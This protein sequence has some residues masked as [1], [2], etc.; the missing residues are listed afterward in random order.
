MSAAPTSAGRWLGT[1]GGAADLPHGRY[2]R[3]VNGSGGDTGYDYQANA[4]A[5]VAAHAL[6]GQPLGWFD[7]QHDI[8]E[9]W[10]AETG[11]PGDDIRVIST[12]RLPIEI[13]A[14][15]G[16]Q[17]GEEY[18][19]TFRKLV[20]GLR[21]SPELRAVLVV[22][23]HASRIIRDDLK[24]DLVRLGQGRTDVITPITSDLL[25]ELG[26][27][28][29]TDTGVFA[30]L[31][32]VVID[33]DDGADGVSV[34]K[35]LLSRVVPPHKSS[36]AYM[37]LGKRGHHM[38]KHRGQ[39]DVLR[40]ARYLDTEVGLSSTTPSPAKSII[41]FQKWIRSTN[42]TFYSPAM[43]RHYPVSHAWN[44]VTPME[45]PAASEA[46]VKGSL[47]VDIQIKRYQEWF[48]LVHRGRGDDVLPAELF[49]DSHRLSVIVGGPGSGKS[50]LSKRLAILAAEENMAVRVR[51]PTVAA[52]LGNAN[53]FERALVEAA[54]DSSG[55][56][57][58]DGERIVGLADLLI[59]DG[60]DECDPHRA[61]VAGALVQWAEGHARASICV[62]TR[63]IGHAPELL[64][65]FAHA[66]LVPLD[67]ADIRRLA[68]WM[69]VSQTSETKS[70]TT[71]LDD[72][73]FALGEGDGHNVKSIAARNPLLL[74]FLVRLFLDGESLDG[75]RSALFERI[76]ELI[77]KSPPLSRKATGPM[78]DK[79]TAWAA[80][81]IAG[82]SC[83][84]RSNRSV[85]DVCELVAAGLGGGL[86]AVRRAESAIRQWT[87]HGLLEQLTVGSLDALV[88]VHLALGEYLAGRHL[89]KLNTE[90]LVLEIERCRRKV[91]WR[92]PIVLA[93][94]SGA[95]ERI[96]PILLSLDSPADP[97]STESVLAAAA[98]TECDSDVV[99]ADTVQS[100]LERLKSRLYSPV[101]VIAVEAGLGLMDLAGWMP[102]FVASIAVE[103]WN[104]EQEWTRLAASCAGLSTGSRMIP[105]DDV[106]RWLKQFRP[107]SAFATLSKTPRRP[108]GFR[109][110]HEA[111]LPKALRRVAE[112]LP[113]ET[114]ERLISAA[115]RQ[116][117]LSFAMFEA[118]R[119]ELSE[120]PYNSWVSR[121]S[122]E[123]VGN[124][125]VSVL[126]LHDDVSRASKA[127]RT[128]YVRVAKCILAVCGATQ[129]TT[130]PELAE[131]RLI[132]R[133]FSSMGY[134]EMSFR[135]FAPL[136]RDDAD[137]VLEVVLRGIISSLRLDPARLGIEAN[138]WLNR[139]LTSSEAAW[140]PSGAKQELDRDA[141]V[142]T[143]LDLN[144]LA[145]ALLH[146]SQFI[147]WNAA[148]LFELHGSGPDQ[149][150]LLK[151]V[152]STGGE[153][154]LL[155]VGSLADTI[156]GSQ[157]FELLFR[158]LGE[159]LSDGCQHLYDPM[160]KA[161]KSPEQLAL[162]VQ[163]TLDAVAQE[164]TRLAPSAAEAL[165]AV[166]ENV[167]ALHAKRIRALMDDWKRRKVLCQECGKPVSGA[168]CETCHIVPPTPRKHLVYL[169]SK[170]GALS[171]EELVEFAEDE[172]LGTQEEGRHALVRLAFENPV[173]LEKVL[174]YIQTG[175]APVRLLDEMLSQP[176]D[177]LGRI[178]DQILALLHS[179]PPPVRERIV[180]SLD[181]GWL[182]T[183][184]ARELAQKALADGAPEVRSR[185]VEVLRRQS[186]V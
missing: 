39:D 132:G 162:A 151:S 125:A 40:C 68:G 143:E 183:E 124:T 147:A 120:E 131:Y 139:L 7:G 46:S 145:K 99:S 23:R 134:W 44:R 56:N 57:Y 4:I 186:Q 138:A 48:R 180:R 19:G 103:L 88:F 152:L 106:V 112:D 43:Q 78:P 164:D 55:C 123:L 91:K 82:W 81:E 168:S 133:L 29:Y 130:T 37:L 116:G 93:A 54:I 126:A 79:P 21:S 3:A 148:R 8:P 109:R 161:A 31:R 175:L 66:E 17:R 172:D 113:Q 85:A 73:M 10:L 11:G 28:G 62:L 114:A 38:I 160:I 110:L 49:V 155:L 67:T 63:P 25:N 84:D 20:N 15:H 9:V 157:A 92:E 173:V 182:A 86:E 65:G 137:P 129:D 178:S 122:G 34:A 42:G 94:G 115:L 41:Q 5:Y 61:D 77:R 2:T 12:E 104:H 36:A 167:L 107:E 165:R 32:I 6:A 146:P 179:S 50:T 118:A 51:L 24:N 97:E 53:T 119:S 170:A 64:P 153:Q 181:S 150:E 142:G 33:L 72:L 13:Q 174:A 71:L 89:T 22:D 80:A 128:G 100:V 140:P 144:V 26:K 102:D 171:A 141:L 163:R 1:F 135:D 74:S 111:A 158:R 117:D 60:L 95:A 87:E 35:V 18:D 90:T 177:Q 16:L 59:A 83:I 96:I 156:W 75:K 185:A 108:A 45:K 52:S 149:K 184:T 166:D 136:C 159:T 27:H 30:R 154:G 169:L 47:A 121:I 101:P 58:A 76:V 69:L 70:S 14:K 127:A 98:L 176:I 105:I